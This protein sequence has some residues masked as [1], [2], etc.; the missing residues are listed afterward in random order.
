MLDSKVNLCEARGRGSTV[1]RIEMTRRNWR[2]ILML[3][4]ISTDVIAI[5]LN[6]FFVYFIRAFT[7]N[8]PK[9]PSQICFSLGI[10]FGSTLVVFAMMVGVCRVTL[11][12]NTLRQC[13]LGGNAHI[14]RFVL[15]SS[16]GTSL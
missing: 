10:L 13:L 9:V 8:P 3:I 14:C 11:H 6:G 15:A 1:G 4:A 16:L 5:L 2:A 7:S 12:G